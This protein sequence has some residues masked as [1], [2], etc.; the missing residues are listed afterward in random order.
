MTMFQLFKKFVNFI[1]LSINTRYPN[2]VKLF[3]TYFYLILGYKDDGDKLKKITNIKLLPENITQRFHDKEAILLS[4]IQKSGSQWTQYLITNYYNLKLNLNIKNPQLEDF[5]IT[6]DNPNQIPNIPIKLY[7]YHILAFNGQITNL[8]A[9]KKIISYRN[10]LDY[11]CSMYSMA[12][13]YNIQGVAKKSLPNNIAAITHQYAKSY[14]YLKQFFNRKDCFIFTYEN[15]KQ[16]TENVFINLLTFI[17]NN[18]DKTCALKSIEL[19]SASNFK[20]N[21]ETYN[22]TK[23]SHIV[24][25]N[26]GRWK[27]EINTKNVK[28]IE[29]ILSQY[30]ISLDEFILE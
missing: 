19:S 28:I 5:F 26:I 4:T 20:K 17:N 18:V 1:V 12:T 8:F 29:S 13:R 7:N 23:N 22:S 6:L 21:I 10:P 9:G 2:S 11:I 14:Y 15:L 24:S 27:N 25:G 3:V 30:N 16:N